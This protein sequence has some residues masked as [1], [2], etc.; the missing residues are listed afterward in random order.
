MLS[1][2]KKPGECVGKAGSET[3][4]VILLQGRQGL[5]GSGQS[6][7]AVRG[8][9]LGFWEKSSLA[10]SPASYTTSLRLSFLTEKRNTATV[11][12]LERMVRIE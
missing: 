10:S 5:P 4:S 1:L 2:W 6:S 12:G 9:G 11:R 3:A 7:L 8:L